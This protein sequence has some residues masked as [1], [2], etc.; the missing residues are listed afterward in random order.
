MYVQALLDVFSDELWVRPAII[1]MAQTLYTLSAQVCVWEGGMSVCLHD[2][3][4]V[5]FG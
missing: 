5:Q 1:G 4:Q 2:L 3:Q